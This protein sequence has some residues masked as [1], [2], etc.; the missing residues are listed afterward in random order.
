[1]NILSEPNLY[2]ML[3]N[4]K[5]VNSL[6]F[7]DNFCKFNKISPEQK[8]NWTSKFIKNESEL[9]LGENNFLNYSKKNSEFMSDIFSKVNE[10]GINK[11]NNK[12]KLEIFSNE[13]NGDYNHLNHK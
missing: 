13:A 7:D 11:S 10:L 12:K 2:K 5:L 4:I 3:L 6:V 8:L 9:F 1:M